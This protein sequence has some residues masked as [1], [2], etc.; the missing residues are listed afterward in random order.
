[1]LA[2]FMKYNKLSKARAIPHQKNANNIEVIR[3]LRAG[4]QEPVRITFNNA[5]LFSDVAAKLTVKLELDSVP[6]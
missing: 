5:R 1:M 2:K 4:E 3:K 6:F